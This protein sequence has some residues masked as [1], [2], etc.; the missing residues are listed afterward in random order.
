MKV[1][2]GNPYYSYKNELYHYGVLGMK[3]GV[4][5]YQKYE[6][7]PIKSKVTGKEVM[8]KVVTGYDPIKRD[9]VALKS[10]KKLNKLVDKKTKYDKQYRNYNSK[11]LNYNLKSSIAK[12]NKKAEK[13]RSKAYK[14][15]SKTVKA[16]KRYQ[17]YTKKAE[18]WVKAMNKYIGADPVT[19]LNQN[20][21]TLGKRYAVD[22]AFNS[23]P[24]KKEG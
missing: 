9:K 8:K 4:R 18:R 11:Y 19:N 23:V 6:K 15:A 7:Q 16:N 12:K 20:L 13:Y 24:E 10:M 21:I 2:Y 17:K 3:W 14:Y 22:L 5:R 1:F